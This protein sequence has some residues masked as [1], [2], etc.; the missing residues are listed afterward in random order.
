MGRTGLKG[1]DRNITLFYW[2][3]LTKFA[4]FHVAV[5]VPFYRSRGLSFSEIMLVQAV[6]YLAKGLLDVPTGAL[7]DS[8]GRRRVLVLGSVVSGLSYLLIFGSRSLPLFMLGE[9][10]SGLG[11]SLSSSADSAMAYDTLLAQ[12]R[13]RHY[14]RVEGNAY[15]LRLAAMGL[16]PVAGSALAT[17]GLGLPYLASAAVIL[18][19]GLFAV[20]LHEPAPVSPAAQLGRDLGQVGRTVWQGAREVARSPRLLWLTVYYG[21]VFCVVRCAFWLFQP[22]LE[23]ARLPLGLFGLVFAALSLFAA[24]ASRAA[25]RV[26]KLAGEAAVLAGMPL[27]SAAAFLLMA[28]EPTLAGLGFLFLH[29]VPF[30]LHEPVLRAYTNAVADSR[31][32]ATVLSVQSLGGNLA[33]ALASIGLGRLVDWLGLPGACRWLAV[34]AMAAALPLGWWYRRVAGPSQRLARR[35]GRP[36]GGRVGWGEEEPDRLRT[37]AHDW[38]S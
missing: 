15:A 17:R 32:R 7:A 23:E 3:R 21:F 10:L 30:G 38:R 20:G 11:M 36:A 18:L 12:G 29:Q 37:K 16:F 2:Y 19:S 25:E 28:R 35:R 26:E 6:Y 33:Y 34:A 27:L 4:L 22:F 13:G 8:L 24:F 9:G 14:Q 1:L 31:V 5:L